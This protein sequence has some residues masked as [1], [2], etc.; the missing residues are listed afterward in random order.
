MFIIMH[1]KNNGLLNTMES[2]KVSDRRAKSLCQKLSVRAK[3]EKR[4]KSRAW[5]RGTQKSLANIK[6]TKL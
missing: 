6:C 3:I 2:Q 1:Q 4:S 5:I